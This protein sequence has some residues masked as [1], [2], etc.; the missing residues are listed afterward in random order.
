MENQRGCEIKERNSGNLLSLLGFFLTCGNDLRTGA[1]RDLTGST[2][3]VPFLTLC[4]QGGR[5]NVFR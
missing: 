4:V 3:K 1:K 5:I 2:F